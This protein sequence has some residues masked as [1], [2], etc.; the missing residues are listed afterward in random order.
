MSHLSVSAYTTDDGAIVEEVDVA[1]NP[2]AT[3]ADV[4]AAEMAALLMFVVLMTI[5]PCFRR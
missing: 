1:K 5:S 4:R 2:P 3:A